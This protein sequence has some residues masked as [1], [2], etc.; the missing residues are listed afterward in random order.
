LLSYFG[1]KNTKPCGKCDICLKKNETILSDADFEEIRVTIREA[2]TIESLSVNALVK[3]VKHKEPKVIK[4]IRF[5]MDNG[6]IIENEMI[7][8]EIK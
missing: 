3:K 5:M 7:K 8:L 1:E 2:L 6:Q 4:V